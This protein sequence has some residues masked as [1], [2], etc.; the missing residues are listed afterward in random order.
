[1][2]E[3]APPPGARRARALQR[4]A[5]QARALWPVRLMP[6]TRAGARQVAR[7]LA[8]DHAEAA[9]AYAAAGSDPPRPLHADRVWRPAPWCAPVRGL[10]GAAPSP[11]AEVA[12]DTRLFHD[13]P[14]EARPGARLRVAATADGPGPAG[15]MLEWRGF[16][17]RFLSLAIDLPAAAC[18]GL[19]ADHLIVAHLVLGL[20]PGVPANLRLNVVSGP[21]VVAR[22]VR[23]RPPSGPGGGA[24][25]AVFDM[26]DVAPPRGVDRMWCDLVLSHLPDAGTVRIADLSMARRPRARV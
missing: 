21:N 7:L 24:L 12:A 14:D 9:R 3:A 17:A 20:P 4:T 6:T 25:V 22:A 15:L 11:G 2:A 1:M 26:I 13:L 19:G 10:D 16:G 8:A 23:L 18:D 5:A